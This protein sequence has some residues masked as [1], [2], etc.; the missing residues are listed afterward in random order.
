MYNFDMKLLISSLLVFE[1]CAD[2]VVYRPRKLKSGARTSGTARAGV[3]KDLAVANG[4]DASEEVRQTR[5]IFP[6]APSPCLSSSINIIL[7]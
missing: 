4:A 3:G 5:F 2:H 1:Q 7:A 6:V